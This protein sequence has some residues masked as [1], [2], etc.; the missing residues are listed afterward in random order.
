MNF[1]DLGIIIIA[2][3]F[4]Y[5][6]QRR[7]LTNELLNLFGLLFALLASLLFYPNVANLITTF[8]AIPKIAINPIAFLLSWLI[9]E[10]VY[11]FATYQLA[12]RYLV[13]LV[14]KPFDKYLAFVPGVINSLLFSAFVLLFLVSI[15]I[16]P[17]FKKS[18]FDSKIG[19]P[20]ISYATVL[21]QPFNSIFGPIAKQSLTFLTVNPEEK[22]SV[23]LGYQQDQLTVDYAGEQEIFNLVNQERAKIGVQPLVWDE[24]RARLARAHSQDMFKR[25]YFSHY[26]PEGKDVGDRLAEAGIT[27]EIAG[28]NLALA[29]SISSAHAGLMNSPGHKRNILDP[30]FNKVGIGVIDGGVYG[31]MVTQV[32]TN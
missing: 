3:F 32:F 15:P 8:F 4:I 29:P 31:K 14:D 12:K 25:G 22:G 21:E 23:T 30:A 24:T 2:V 1:I 10:T 9:F 28:E 17:I 11:S 19:S 13:K 16:S 6:S 18:I 5:E 26:S 7:G 27:Y 20:L